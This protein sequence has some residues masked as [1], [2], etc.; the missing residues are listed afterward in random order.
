VPINI[1]KENIINE[2][3]LYKDTPNNII[4]SEIKFKVGGA[5][6][7]QQIKRKNHNLILNM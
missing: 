1:I 7:L 4:S 3:I 2:K 6:I 5:E